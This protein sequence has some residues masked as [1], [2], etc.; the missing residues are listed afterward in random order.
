[1]VGLWR[2]KLTVHFNL[3][4][5]LCIGDFSSSGAAMKLLCVKMHCS[6]EYLE[7]TLKAKLSSNENTKC[8]VEI[9]IVV[10]LMFTGWKNTKALSGYVSH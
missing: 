6:C 1:M 8:V 3:E 10:Y 7:L 4:L 9:W 5:G 2:L